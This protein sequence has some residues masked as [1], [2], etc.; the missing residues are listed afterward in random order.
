VEFHEDLCK[1]SD[2]LVLEGMN[3][4][5]FD[6]LSSMALNGG[7]QASN[8]FMIKL[9]QLLEPLAKIHEL[10]IVHNDI[11]VENIMFKKQ[12]KL[13][14]FDLATENLEKFLPS[15]HEMYWSPQHQ[16]Q[17]E[18]RYVFANVFKKFEA[19]ENSIDLKKEDVYALG[20]AC[21]LFMAP[22]LANRLLNEKQTKYFV[23]MYTPLAKYLEHKKQLRMDW[24][25]KHYTLEDN[26]GELNTW[27]SYH[28]W[29][30]SFIA[31]S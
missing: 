6:I 24:Q 14:D 18:N 3:V 5:G 29:L 21:L 9:L 1:N 16:K 8:D 28:T 13:I 23:E 12:W 15:G 17:Y 30:T 2:E 4:D 11:S 31:D 10:G 26:D 22:D 25:R 19:L 27:E 7:K 20:I